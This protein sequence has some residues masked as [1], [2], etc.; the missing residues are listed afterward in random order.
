MKKLSIFQVILLCVFGAFA[1]AGVAVFSI[2]VGGR[3]NSATGPVVIWGTLDKNA[4]SSVL[5]S[6]ADGNSDFLQVTYVEK[7]PETFMS[8]VTNALAEGQG[9][10]LMLL[11]QDYAYSQASRVLPI[12]KEVLS[13]EQFT[14]LFADAAQPFIHP[15]GVLAVP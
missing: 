3:N 7:D 4:F 10:D 6:L 9:P 8:E 2:A 13:P 12:S 14:S 15:D 5:Q 1:I 11:R